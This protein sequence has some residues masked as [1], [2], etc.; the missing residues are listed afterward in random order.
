VRAEE[1]RDY[2]FAGRLTPE[3]GVRMIAEWARDSRRRVRFIG[4]GPEAEALRNY[5][6]FCNVTGWLPPDEV[7]HEML[8]ARALLFPVHW[9]ETFGL[10][11]AEALAMGLPVVVSG[12]AGAAERVDHGE[13][14]WV[15]PETDKKSSFGQAMKH[16]EE[17]RLVEQMSREAYRRYWEE[18]MSRSA[19]AKSLLQ[20][21][22]SLA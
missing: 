18:P 12:I 10:V 8:T 16:L 1:N 6:E 5:G 4:E 13:T 3:K 19:H 7:K 21:Y 20:W 14:G 17:S 22:Q 15:L 11:V 2:I 9:P